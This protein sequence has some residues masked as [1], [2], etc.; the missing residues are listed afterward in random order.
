MEAEISITSPWHKRLQL[1]RRHNGPRLHC[2]H[3]SS[4]TVDCDMWPV[5]SVG[6][7]F[8]EVDDS[9][10]QLRTSLW[11]VNREAV[12]VGVGV[13]CKLIHRVYRSHVIQHKEQDGS[14][15][16]TGPISLQTTQIHSPLM[17]DGWG[18]QQ[19]PT[20]RWRHHTHHDS[21]TGLKAEEARGQKPAPIYYFQSNSLPYSNQRT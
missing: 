18:L 11:L 3:N 21:M 2:H 20:P 13:Q 12:Q 6:V 7:I 19:W 1:L 4:P 14:A 9:L 10:V 17:T 5:H 15:L 8:I 16:R